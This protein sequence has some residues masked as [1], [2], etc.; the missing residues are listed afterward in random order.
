MSCLYKSLSPGHE[1][2]TSKQNALRTTE[3]RKQIG[4]LTAAEGSRNC[5]DILSGLM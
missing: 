5:G 4:T 1:I 2:A 3:E